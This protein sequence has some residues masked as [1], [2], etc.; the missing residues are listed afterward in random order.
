MI[1][2]GKTCDHKDDPFR[3][4][5]PEGDHQKDNSHEV[6]YPQGFFCMIQR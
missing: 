5:N 4:L 2:E 1:S 3:R 6:P